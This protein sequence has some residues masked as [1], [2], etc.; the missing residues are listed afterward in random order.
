MHYYYSVD[1]K[2]YVPSMVVKTPV[3]AKKVFKREISVATEH[4]FKYSR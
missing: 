4:V 2:L 3:E 1:F